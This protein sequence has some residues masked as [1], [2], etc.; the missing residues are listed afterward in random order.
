MVDRA[1][2]FAAVCARHN[3]PLT[4]A[5][6]QFAGAHPAVTCVLTGVR[7]ADELR[8]NVAD[9]Q[10]PIP[11]AL[12]ADLRAERLLDDRVPTP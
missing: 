5:A 7:S 8:A 11:E 12:W 10:R 4:A 2:A 6:L 9:F 1:R 3:V